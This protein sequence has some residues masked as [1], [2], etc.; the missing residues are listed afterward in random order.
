MW[1]IVLILDISAW[2][3]TVNINPIRIVS[4]DKEEMG[5]LLRRKSISWKRQS[6]EKTEYY[7]KKEWIFPCEFRNSMAVSVMTV[8]YIFKLENKY[9]CIFP[10]CEDLFAFSFG[11][12]EVRKWMIILFNCV[13]VRKIPVSNC[14]R[15][16]TDIH[17]IRERV[18]VY[19]FS[20]Y[21]VIW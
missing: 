13:N 2:N 12:F 10:T 4:R 11:T 6:W 19:S 1:Q 17:F 7:N 21:N 20:I 8:K 15:L 14:H 9:S 16:K 3:R 5:E 18:G